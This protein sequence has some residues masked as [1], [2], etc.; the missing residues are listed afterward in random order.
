MNLSRLTFN[1]K[2][3]KPENNKYYK[4]LLLNLTINITNFFWG[5][6]AFSKFFSIT[7]LHYRGSTNG[8]HSLIWSERGDIK[9]K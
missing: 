1:I 2:W 3:V 4:N 6:G 9:S 8:S 7:S 5:G